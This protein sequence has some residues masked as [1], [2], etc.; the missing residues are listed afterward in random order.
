MV[1]RFLGKIKKKNLIK[2]LFKKDQWLSD[3]LNKNVFKL[4]D[5]SDIDE[6]YLLKSFN[7]LLREY[8]DDDLFIF[9]KVSTN[10]INQ[11]IKIENLGFRL[12]D[13]NILFSGNSK[14][15]YKKNIKNNIYIKFSE[16]SYK[17]CIGDIAY[18]NFVFSRFHLDPNI[19]KPKL[20]ILKLGRKLFFW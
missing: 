15:N 19:K 2:F 5:I 11:I 18:N 8:L 16:S 10:L 17:S 9:V 4:T 3:V 1:Q 14:I 12:I 13:T 7:D 20:I 6:D